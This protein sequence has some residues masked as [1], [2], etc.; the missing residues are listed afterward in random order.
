MASKIEIQVVPEKCTGCR[1]CELICS[2]GKHEEFNPKRSRVRIVK[3]ERFFIDIPSICQHCSNPLCL[4]DCD[5][6]AIEKT[7]EGYVVVDQEKCIAC[8]ECVA[9][10]PFDSIFMDPVDNKAIVCDLCQ[11]NPKCVQWCPTE[12]LTLQKDDSRTGR[13]KRTSSVKEA[14]RL[15][16]R[17]K[18]PMKEW[19]RYH[20]KKNTH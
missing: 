7:K 4:K 2:A 10:C 12:A 16:Q 19:E 11:G 14:R 6:G 13:K 9:A 17:W 8:E 1:I 15:I 18:I 20:Q 5:S 3:E